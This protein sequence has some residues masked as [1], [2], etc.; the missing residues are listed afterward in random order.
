[1]TQQSSQD[2]RSPF[3]Q[4]IR[5]TGIIVL[6]ILIFVGVAAWW[7]IRTV[8]DNTLSIDTPTSINITPQQIE[9]IRDIGQWEFLAVTD[10][11]LVDTVRKG[12]FKNDRLSRIYYGVVRIGVDLTKTKKGW[13]AVRGD[14]VVATLPAVGVLDNRFIDEART[15]SF[16]ESGKWSAADREA[17]YRKAQRQMLSH[18]LTPQNLRSAE[19]QADAQL[20]KLLMAMGFE[21]VEVHFEQ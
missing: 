6:V 8:T 9:S 4:A 5:W 7:I 11:E 3:I 18:A 13:L 10:E 2:G 12:L 20:R 19:E 17:L 16:H 15:Q 1:M 14:T 21:H